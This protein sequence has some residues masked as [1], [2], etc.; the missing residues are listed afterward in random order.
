MGSEEVGG[1]HKVNG[2][3]SKKIRKEAEVD[4]SLVHVFVR[5][6]SGLPLKKRIKF[7]ASILFKRPYK[8]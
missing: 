8:G 5:G 3:I 7:C 4:V 2:R 1:R 6:V